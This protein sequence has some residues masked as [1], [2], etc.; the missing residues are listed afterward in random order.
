MH[1][2]QQDH[3]DPEEVRAKAVAS[4]CPGGGC[5]V[6]TR[7]QVSVQGTYWRDH[8]SEEPFDESTSLDKSSP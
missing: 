4:S 1:Q 3:K 5:R 2:H 8:V 7:E 6:T